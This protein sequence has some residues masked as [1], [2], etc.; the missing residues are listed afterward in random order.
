MSG[1][2]LHQPFG[3]LLSAFDRSQLLVLQYERCRQDPAPE[4]ARTYRFLDLDDAYIPESLNRKINTRPYTVPELTPNERLILADYF[5][6]DVL[7][8]ADL[9]PEIDLSLW[10]DFE[11]IRGSG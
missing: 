1:V 3:R 7:A 11:G 6:Q 10:P 5:A 8:V 9:F 2:S 4:I